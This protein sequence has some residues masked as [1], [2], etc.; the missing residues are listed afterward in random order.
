MSLR[1]LCVTDASDRP[2]AET[3]IGLKKAGVEIEVMCRTDARHY[4]RLVAAGV[5]VT[6]LRLKRRFDFRG[7][8]AIRRKLQQGRFD[9][10][11]LFCNKTASNG[12]TAAYGLP[13]KIVCYRGIVANVSFLDPVSW[14]TYLNPRVS[15]IICVADAIRDYFLQMRLLWMR[16]SPDKVVTIHKGH[17]LDWYQDAPVD[18]AEFGIPTGAFV[19]GFAGRDR[20]RKGIEVLVESARHLPP[21]AAIHFLL[22]GRLQRRSL[23]ELIAASPYRDR[24]HLTGYRTDAPSLAAAC[25]AFVMPSLKRE[26]LPRAVIEAMAYG[27]P[28]IVSDTGGSAELVVPGE[29]G[30][31]IRAGDAADLA[32]AILELY[33]DPKKQQRMGEMARERIASSFTNE[34]T[35]RKTLAL[36]RELVAG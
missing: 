24:I 7:M 29:S 26:G 23:M 28:P 32:K 2:E 17:S 13:V 10:L 36:Y 6:G 1:V 34:E 4:E 18:L 9:I 8:A 35:V 30:L 5:P 15:R 19:V 25:S 33:M 3:F 11:H 20:P 12:V 16:V 22:V 31:V 14:A 21:D 27:V